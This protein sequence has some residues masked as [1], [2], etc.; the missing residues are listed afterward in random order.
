MRWL[1][2]STSFRR[3]G[4]PFNRGEC[5]LR[6]L[7]NTQ[8]TLSNNRAGRGPKYSGTLHSFHGN[9]VVNNMPRRRIA[10]ILEPP[11]RPAAIPSY[12]IDDGSLIHRFRAGDR[13]AFTA[14]YR[15]HHAATT[16]IRRSTHVAADSE[17]RST[18]STTCTRSMLIRS[19]STSRT[20]SK[21][22]GG[23][24]QTSS[25]DERAWD[26]LQVSRARSAGCPS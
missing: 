21:N 11:T 14:L 3:H 26:A 20:P 23:L 1:L 18:R 24:P 12:V 13:D 8:W 9:I 19:S 17:I 7:M 5:S 15:A 4:Q 25:H 2:R 10:N 22:S 16:R 6:H